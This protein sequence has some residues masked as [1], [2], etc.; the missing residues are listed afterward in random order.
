MAYDTQWN[1]WDSMRMEMTEE[2]K[3][4]QMRKKNK[5]KLCLMSRRAYAYAYA[6]MHAVVE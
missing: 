1:S 4:Q 2:V 3:K 6:C 5:G